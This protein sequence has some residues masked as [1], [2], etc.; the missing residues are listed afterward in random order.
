[1]ACTPLLSKEL[2]TQNSRSFLKFIINLR[3]QIRYQQTK[4]NKFCLIHSCSNWKHS[5][6][7]SNLTLVMW[8]IWCSSTRRPLLQIRRSN[9]WIS[10][11]A[12]PKQTRTL[13]KIRT[14]RSFRC[15]MHSTRILTK[16]T[17]L[18]LRIISFKR[19]CKTICQRQAM[20]SISWQIRWLINL[21][22]DKSSCKTMTN[23]CKNNKVPLLL[24]TNLLYNR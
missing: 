7:I 11:M 9:D 19:S 12:S 1:M 5:I 16:R 14:R 8:K 3:L 13:L 23:F 15:W 18:T 22:L 2:V 17:A 24:E 4:T 21:Q 20:D 10:R 6:R